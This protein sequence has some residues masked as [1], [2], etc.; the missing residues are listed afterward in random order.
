MRFSAVLRL[1]LLGALFQLAPVPTSAAAMDGELEIRLPRDP[2]LS[3]SGEVL[4]FAWRRDIWIATVEGGAASRLT[5]HTADDQDPFFSPDGKTIAYSSDRTGQRQIHLLSLVG[6][7]PRQVTFGS[8]GNTLLGFTADGAGLVVLRTTD[9]FFHSSESRRVFVI[10]LAGEKPA[11]MLFDVGVADAALSPD[12]T[13]VLFTRGRASWNRKGYVGPAALQM[14]I[15]DLSSDSPTLTRLDKDRSEFQNVSWME[16][17]WAPGGDAFYYVSDPDGTFDLYRRELGSSKSTRVTTVGK[18]DDSDDGVS[19]PAMSGD[20]SAVVF[21][22]RFDLM[23]LDLASGSVEPIALTATGDLAADGFERRLEDSASS[24]AYTSDGK[25]MAFVSGQDIYVMDRILKEPVRVTHTAESESDLIF[26]SDDSRLLFVTDSGGE[27]DIWEATHAQESGIWW[28]A[29]DFSL[30]QVTD[31]REAEG[32]LRLSP[33]GGLVAYTRA[34]DLFVMGDDGSEQRE[35]LKAWSRPSFDWSPDGRWLAYA[36]QDDNYNSDVHIVPVDGSSEPFNLSRHPD[37]DTSP[38]WSGDG[39]RIA[40]V[41]RRDGTESD[42]YYVNLTKEEEEGTDRDT[43][44]E[45]ALEAM[46]EKGGKKGSKKEDSKE[47]EADAEEDAGDATPEG[48]QDSDNAEDAEEEEEEAEDEDPMQIDFE[49]IHERMHRISIPDSM[50]MGLIWSP[51]GERLA[52]SATVDGKRAFYSVKFPDVEDPEKF[53]ETGLGQSRWLQSGKEIVGLERSGTPAAMDEKG[54]LSSFD[55]SVRRTRD[56]SRVRQVA[57]DQAWRAMRDGFYDPN[58]NNRD[59]EEIRAKYRPVAA[60]VIGAAEFSEMMNMMLGELNA[61]HMGH[62]GGAG[63]L[64]KPSTDDSWSPRTFELGLRFALGGTGPGLVVSSVIPG[65]PCDEDRA[66]VEVGETL[67]AIDGVSLDPSVDIE[68]LLTMEQVRDVELVVANPDG[69][70]RTFN[71]RPVTSVRGLLYDE[72]V[73]NTRA[74]VDELSGGTLGYLHI[75][76]MNMSSF[77]QMEEDL[78]HAGDGKEGLIIDVRFNGGGSTTDHV[79]TALTQPVHAIT[80]SRGSGEGYPQDR[81]I[82]ASWSKP[83]ILMCNEHS[84]SNAEILAHAVKL[85]GRGRLVGMRTAGGVISTG[86]VGLLDG[87]SV[88]MPRRGWYLAGTGEDMELNGCMP[89]IALWNAPGGEDLQLSTA[90]EALLQDVLKEQAQASVELVPAATKR[91]SEDESR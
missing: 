12:G 11:H 1:A 13:Q 52:F 6:D 17:M 40:F 86:S 20:G 19:F 71:V 85:I 80:L 68:R 63:P 70:S 18:A 7:A 23:H 53:A 64:P 8:A 14:W 65:S 66:L 83:I 48:D 61:S 39:E 62:R 73:E 47:D 58:T 35:L 55:F 44:M 49:G 82:Y 15:A 72:F 24:V 56:W 25:Q 43:L 32:S 81:K 78:F 87:S 57:F 77:L 69:E 84:F 33:K 21:R 45:E 30:R 74:Q 60:Q 3:P 34:T 29:E 41:S 75:R 79:L 26:S 9:R 51:D 89:D 10:D 90:V 38:V 31:D 42:I 91:A 67:L 16:P 88:R 28:L 2:A 59:W 4:A 76:G 27:L 37:R 22:R 54:K 5:L 46:E 36:T 50:E